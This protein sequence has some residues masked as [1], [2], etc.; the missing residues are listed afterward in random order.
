MKSWLKENNIR[1]SEC[2]EKQQIGPIRVCDLKCFMIKAT[3][4]VTERER[5]RERE[6]ES[7]KGV[8]ICYV[9]CI[10][11]TVATTYQV[12]ICYIGRYLLRQQI[13]MV[14]IC[15]QR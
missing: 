13:G 14:G 8:G 3:Y 1:R 11:A 10:F 9:N 12:G 4:F 7:Q 5:E 15:Y 6:R 2:F